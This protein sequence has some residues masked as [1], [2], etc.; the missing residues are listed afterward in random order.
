M[1]WGGQKSKSRPFSTSL[2]ASLQYIDD[3]RTVPV[4]QPSWRRSPAGRGGPIAP[5]QLHLCSS[6]HSGLGGGKYLWQ[7]STRVSPITLP[8]V[9]GGP[10]IVTRRRRWGSRPSNPD[11]PVIRWWGPLLHRRCGRRRWLYGRDICAR[12]RRRIPHQREPELV[13]FERKGRM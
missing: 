9:D 13:C 5:P 2:H 1:K 11:A 6:S 7:C 10:R 8:D 4:Q 3:V 12:M